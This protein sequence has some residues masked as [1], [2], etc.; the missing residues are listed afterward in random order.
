MSVTGEQIF[1]SG[2][3]GVLGP[4]GILSQIAQDLQ[5][6]TTA[7]LAKVQTTDA[8]ALS[9]AIT[10]VT[11]VAAQLGAAYQSMQTFAQQ[12]TNTQQTL[13]AQISEIDSTNVA[14]VSTQLTQ[15][16]NSYQSALWATSQLSQESL[17]QFLN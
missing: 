13:Q 10:Q 7:S 14:Q 5:T 9:T 6:G 4:S 11:T 1:G 16:Q 15:A 3:T 8:Q 17:V 2:S 12:A